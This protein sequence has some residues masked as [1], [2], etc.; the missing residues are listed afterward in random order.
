MKWVGRVALVLLLV[1]TL[2]AAKQVE[3]QIDTAQAQ[4]QQDLVVCF[5]NLQVVVQKDDNSLAQYPQ[6][7]YLD[8]QSYRVFFNGIT[9]TNPTSQTVYIRARAQLSTANGWSYCVRDCGF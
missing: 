6:T 8:Y 7:G 4:S 9:V 3:P 2:L 5:N 1:T